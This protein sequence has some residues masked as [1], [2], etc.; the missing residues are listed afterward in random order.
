MPR[1]SALGLLGTLDEV[2]FHQLL[3]WHHFFDRS[4]ATVARISD[5]LFH[6]A[7]T[8]AIVVG[9]VLLWRAKVKQQDMTRML[10][11]LDL[12][13]SAFSLPGAAIRR[14]TTATS[15]GRTRDQSPDVPSESALARTHENHHL[16]TPVAGRESTRHTST[17]HLIRLPS[18][19]AATNPS[20]RGA[21]RAGSGP[22]VPPAHHS[23]R[24]R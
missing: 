20:W 3:R 13:L 6:L 5:G 2:L 22:D 11:R 15:L 7:S 17:S 12:L 9:G 23:R 14:A 4:D 16:I 21:C 8:G 1:C 18:N 19:A 10:P 24:H